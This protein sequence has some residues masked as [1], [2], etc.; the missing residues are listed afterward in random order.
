MLGACSAEPSQD[1]AVPSKAENTAKP[2][3][4]ALITILGDLNT[5]LEGKDYKGAV[6][7]MQ[8]FPNM[9][10]GE[11]E[12]ALANFQDR[13]EISAKGILILKEKGKFGELLDVFPERAKTFAKN[14][15]VDAAA[16]YAL[17]LDDAEV[18][19]FW[20]GKSFHLIRLDDV[21]KLR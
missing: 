1:S 3:K 4:E 17:S 20:N 12:K 2:N 6:N 10:P 13:G 8:P 21:G 18:V 16:C 9:K 14:A 11:M 7:F 15:G 5:K 19:G